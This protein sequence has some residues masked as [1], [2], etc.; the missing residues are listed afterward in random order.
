MTTGAPF[1]VSPS[2]P[3][4]IT[5]VGPLGL[6]GSINVTTGILAGIDTYFYEWD[7]L[8]N[9]WDVG[10]TVPCVPGS[11]RAVQYAD[12]LACICQ[13]SVSH[14]DIIF[15]TGNEINATTSPAIVVAGGLCGTS[16]AGIAQN[17]RYTYAT[18]SDGTTIWLYAI[19]NV[20]H[21][22]GTVAAL[23]ATYG[24]PDSLCC[25]FDGTVI[26]CLCSAAAVGYPVTVATGAIGTV[27]SWGVVA[28]GRATLWPVAENAA[29]WVLGHVEV[30]AA[31]APWLVGLVP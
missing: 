17:G 21:T 31:P 9:T 20:V 22:I 27:A 23:P 11:I 18:G 4:D 25:S 8:T 15:G 1:A 30:A 6:A 7:D 10:I 2:A 26:Y 29:P 19:D 3:G 28:P 12:E 5:A 24:I 13:D 14:Q 16:T